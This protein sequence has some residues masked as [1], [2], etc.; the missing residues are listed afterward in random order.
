MGWL[1]RHEQPA[2]EIESMRQR[3]IAVCTGSGGLTPGACGV[4]LL[5]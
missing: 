5:Y 1:A 3:L 4:E 2:G